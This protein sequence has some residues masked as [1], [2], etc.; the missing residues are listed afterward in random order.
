MNRKVL[1][2]AAMFNETVTAGIENWLCKT[3]YIFYMED[4]AYWLD[5]GRDSKDSIE[6]LLRR[7]NL[8]E[9][10]IE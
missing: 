6:D 3:D 5:L 1:F 10:M 7:L 4:R 9:M 8:E 2:L